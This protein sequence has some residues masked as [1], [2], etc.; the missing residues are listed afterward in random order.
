M[1]DPGIARVVL[2]VYTALMLV[3]GVMGYVK[4]GSR[5]SL[6]SGILS[7][8]VG[9]AAVV[10]AGRSSNGF[11]LGAA[12]AAVL[13]GLFSVR[14]FRTRKPMPSGMLSAVSLAVL[15]VVIGALA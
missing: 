9:T 1:I 5:P 7:G 10:I 4:A 2:G 11:Y 6:V 12:M 8:I 13:L 14:L 15:L 3:G